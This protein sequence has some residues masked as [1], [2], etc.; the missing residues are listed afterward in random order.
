MRPLQQHSCA[1]NDRQLRSKAAQWAAKNADSVRGVSYSGGQSWKRICVAL[2]TMLA[3]VIPWGDMLLLPYDIQASRVFTLIAAGAWLLYL[4]SGAQVKA[5]EKSHWFLVAFVLWTAANAIWTA[6]PE[7]TARRAL[8]YFQ[9]FLDSW[10]IYQCVDSAKIYR[11]LLGSFLLGCTVAFGGLIYNFASGT[12]QGDGRYT[13]PGFDPNDLAA[14]LILGIPA[15]LYLSFSGTKMGWISWL[16]VPCAMLASM[17]TASRSALI[18]LAICFL[19]PLWS[20]RKVSAR[21]IGTFVLLGVAS[22]AVISYFWSDISFRR[23]ATISEQL[24][25]RDLNGRVDI[26]ERGLDAFLDNPLI[27]VGGGGFG[28]AVGARNRELAAHNVALGILVEHGL[29]GFTLFTAAFLAL[30]FRVRTRTDL[31]SQMWTVTLAGW[32]IAATTLS[33]ENREITWLLWGLCS[34]VT[35]TARNVTSWRQ[36]SHIVGRRLGVHHA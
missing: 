16:Y 36:P 21:A 33:W 26:W 8:S 3:F 9:L 14:T 22:F 4:R 15:A 25:A 19:F 35:I 28:S 13:A 17:L 7:R 2:V 5:L 18:A 32:M 10:L 1:P 34:S 30:L 20:A 6:E 12:Y 27:G 29:V 11:R 31:E 23:L 24:S